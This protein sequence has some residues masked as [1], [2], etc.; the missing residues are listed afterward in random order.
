MRLTKILALIVCMPFAVA[1]QTEMGA[2][3][4]LIEARKTAFDQKNYPGA[5]R[6]CQQALRGSPDYTD[7]RVF[8]GRLYF[9]NDQTDSSRI[10]LDQ[11]VK[12][13]PQ[14]ED[15]AVAAASVAFFTDQYNDCLSYCDG[16]LQHHPKSRDLLM[17]KAKCLT[18][19]RRYKDAVIL[20]D[21]LLNLNKSDAEARDLAFKIKDFRVANK[22]G[23][24]YDYT[25]FSKQ[26]ADPWHLMS[27][28]YTRQTSAGSF[29]GRV[30]HTNRFGEGGWQFEV[31]GYPSIARNLYAYVNLGYSPDMPLFPKY[32]A[33]FSLYASLPRA[34]EAD[35]GFRYLNFDS[36]T[37]IYTG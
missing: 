14:H 25:H 3:E 30:N 5:I 1:A 8:L 13:N 10:T 37:W 17:Q 28:D 16:G 31:D 11:A 9:W 29:T 7:I 21:T 32:R 22:I 34:F 23:V 15:A 36:D 2:D 4:L 35:A 20:T 18:A 24:S 6:L 27:V 26:F 33:G 19:M 12:A